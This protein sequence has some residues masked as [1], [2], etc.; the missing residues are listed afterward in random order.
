MIFL[1]SAS[2]TTDTTSS[3]RLVFYQRKYG[4][5]LFRRISGWQCRKRKSWQSTN[6]SHSSNTNHTQS[7][8]S[9]ILSSNRVTLSKNLFT[10][11][12]R[13][14]GG[15]Y[16]RVSIQFFVNIVSIIR[17]IQNFNSIRR[18]MYEKRENDKILRFRG[19]IKK[20]P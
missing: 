11:G 17:R 20:D 8:S 10:E 19:C 12:I 16:F 18:Y 4:R 3:R 7:S 9:S 6:T 14:N 2:F 15:Y 5:C 13:E 1:F